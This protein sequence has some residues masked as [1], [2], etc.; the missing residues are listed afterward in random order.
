MN[1]FLLLLFEAGVNIAK[2]HVK[3]KTAGEILSTTSFIMDAAK[4]IDD[5]Y[6]EENG[7]PL[8]WSTIR[9]HQHL[10]P[11]GQDAREP[12]GDSEGDQPSLPGVRNDPRETDDS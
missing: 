7:E 8:D 1:P 10:P 2:A 5:L 6:Q 3:N 4:A 9:H 12:A 11:P